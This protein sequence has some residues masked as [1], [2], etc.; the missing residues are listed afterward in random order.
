MSEDARFGFYNT[1]LM[2]RLEAFFARGA[3]AISAADVEGLASCCR[4]DAQAAYAALIAAQ[5]GLDTED[6]PE[7]KA[8][9]RAYFP[10]M[11][12]QLDAARFRADPYYANISFPSAA[13]GSWTLG[14]GRYAPF[15]AFV[16]DDLR[17][18]GDGRI[19]PQLG[20][21]TGQFLFPEVRENGR[22]W[23]SVTPNE[24]A[25]M[26]AP[27]AAAHGD[28]LTY[29]LGL[30]YFVYMASQKSDVRRVV[31]VERDARAIELF[32]QYILPQFPQK[33]KVYLVLSDAFAFARERAPE[34]SFD[35]TF[36]DIWHDPSDGVALYLEMKKLEAASR[37][38]SHMYWIEDTLRHYI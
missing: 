21:F 34:E 15:E 4:V 29:G 23:M 16:C 14:H 30:G 20:Y 10:D 2:R 24:I 33:A 1:I 37:C 6:D 11:L 27:I 5:L 36:T 26:R 9:F 12:H 25:T 18:M 32:S 7:A 17:D 35:F 13:S 3:D 8:L 38:R 31:A 28:V 19:I 22:E